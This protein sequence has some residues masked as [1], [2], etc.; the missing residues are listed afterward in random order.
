[1]CAP[2]SATFVGRV[3]CRGRRARGKPVKTARG[4]NSLLI[5]GVQRAKKAAARCKGESSS[6]SS[7]KEGGEAISARCLLAQS[8]GA[9][10]VERA[11]SWEKEVV[12]IVFSGVYVV[13]WRMGT[14]I[15][16]YYFLG[17]ILCDKINKQI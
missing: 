13:G 3:N 9:Y 2:L 15:V 4:K 5:R 12:G 1:M 7:R 11:L 8:L 17:L 16:F 10:I 14:S 6:S